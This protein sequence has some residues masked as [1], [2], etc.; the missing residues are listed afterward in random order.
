LANATV[1]DFARECRV[2]TLP[3]DA[4]GAARDVTSLVGL[5]PLARLFHLE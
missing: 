1:I 5:T 4:G 2:A 3:S